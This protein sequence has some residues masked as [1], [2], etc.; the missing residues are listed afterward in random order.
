MIIF[1][2]IGLIIMVSS[3]TISN[4]AYINMICNIVGGIMMGGSAYYIIKLEEKKK[5]ELK[6][7]IEK[8]AGKE[9]HENEIRILSSIETLL[10]EHSKIITTIEQNQKKV[11]DI[12]EDNS[13][14]K[15]SIETIK[16]SL[17]AHFSSLEKEI[18]NQNGKLIESSKFQIEELIEDV[19]NISANN[20]KDTKEI[21]GSIKAV[22][23]ANTDVVVE[24]L[25]NIDQ[26]I[27]SINALPREISE[28]VDTL[29]ENLEK[30]IEDIQKA[31][32]N[33]TEDIDDKEEERTN[34]FKSIMSGIQEVTQESNEEMVGEIKNLADQYTMFEKTITTIVEQMSH[35]AEEDIKVM[36]GFLD[37]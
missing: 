25:K 31:Y 34:K 10:Q 24:S 15:E 33:L 5:S 11:V 30:N 18:I 36:K 6:M 32:T 1:F 22:E 17:D 37:E 27:N 26:R 14:M 35:M 12:V 9:E 16:E 4:V 7:S 21:I 29:I 13:E 20:S 23:S 28:L 8:L 3:G 2:F 19:N